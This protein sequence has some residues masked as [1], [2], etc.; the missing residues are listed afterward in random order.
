MVIPSP[1]VPNDADYGVINR[2]KIGHFLMVLNG[3]SEQKI[4]SGDGGDVINR[5]KTGPK[6]T[7]PLD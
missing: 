3:H 2:P 7:V 4:L 1:I 5:P 6:H